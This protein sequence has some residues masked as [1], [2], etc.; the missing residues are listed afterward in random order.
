MMSAIKVIRRSFG[1]VA[2]TYHHVATMVP[3]HQR[4]SE[5]LPQSKYFLLELMSYSILYIHTIL[6]FIAFDSH[7]SFKVSIF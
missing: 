4:L 3:G 5:E 6:F 2:I 7:F 1:C